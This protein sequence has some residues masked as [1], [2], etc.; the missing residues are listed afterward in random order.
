MP[1]YYEDAVSVLLLATNAARELP[2]FFRHLRVCDVLEVLLCDQGSTD[3]TVAVARDQGAGVFR[4]RERIADAVNNA[5][6]HARGE[7]CW[8]LA[9][10]CRPPLHAGHHIAAILRTQAYAGGFYPLASGNPKA[11]GRLARFAGNLAAELFTRLDLRYG[12]FL[13]TEL[14]AKAGGFPDGE[15]PATQLMR[16]VR[17][18]GKLAVLAPPMALAEST[19]AGDPAHEAK[20]RGEIGS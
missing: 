17:K 13:R 14:F 15:N 19:A 2:A 20:T 8:L 3:A 6:R 9:P 10:S 1:E 12:P 7:H 16:G 11:V 4:S 18:A 5:A